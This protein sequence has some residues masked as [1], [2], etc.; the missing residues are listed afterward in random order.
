[1]FAAEIR[2][3]RVT[4]MRAHRDWQWHLYEVNAKINGVTQFL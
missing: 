4:V 3:K 2:V 1:M